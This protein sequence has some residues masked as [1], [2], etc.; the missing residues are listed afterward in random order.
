[1]VAPDRSSQSTLDRPDTGMHLGRCLH[2]TPAAG[3]EIREVVKNGPRQASNGAT[4]SQEDSPADPVSRLIGLLRWNFSHPLQLYACPLEH[5]P[6]GTETVT[7]ALARRGREGG[8]KM[9]R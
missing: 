2:A 7:C 5:H 1:M 8:S 4:Q 9:V 3:A 6:L